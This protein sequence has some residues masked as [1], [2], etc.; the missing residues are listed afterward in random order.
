[1]YFEFVPFRDCFLQKSVSKG[2]KCFIYHQ[3]FVRPSVVHLRR[4]CSHLALL[5]SL[6]LARLYSQK[7]HHFQVNL[8]NNVSAPLCS[9][10][11]TPNSLDLRNSSPPI[12]WTIKNPRAFAAVSGSLHKLAPY[13]A[14]VCCPLIGFSPYST[15][16]V[17]SFV[18]PSEHLCVRLR[19]PF[20]TASSTIHWRLARVSTGTQQ[21]RPAVGLA[22]FVLLGLA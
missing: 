7:N 20:R 5:P 9:C 1:M 13:L 2:I 3:R 14:W 22:V 17:V 21:K 15:C 6:P 16:E 18:R 4:S 11:G 8:E 12:A 19:G 10:S